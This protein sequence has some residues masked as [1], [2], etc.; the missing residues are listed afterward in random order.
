MN[1]KKLVIPV[2]LGLATLTL[3]EFFVQP[4]VAKQLNNSSTGV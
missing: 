4:A 1:A 2:I 3:W